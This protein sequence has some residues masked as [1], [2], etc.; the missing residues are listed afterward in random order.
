MMNAEATG[1]KQVYLLD[2]SRPLMTIAKVS[3]DS[4]VK[5]GVCAS[6]SLSNSLPFTCVCPDNCP[7]AVVNSLSLQS[8]TTV[9]HRP[10]QIPA[11]ACFTPALHLPRPHQTQHK[12][13]Q[14][15]PNFIYNSLQ[16]TSDAEKPRHTK[17]HARGDSALRELSSILDFSVTHRCRYC[18][19]HLR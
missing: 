17:H 19:V 11:A 16:H 10:I 7:N 12:Y 6:N 13:S 18:L 1:R 3:L 8:T 15:Q 4:D 9:I 2:C 5:R 14:S